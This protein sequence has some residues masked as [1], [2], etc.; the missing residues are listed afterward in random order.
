MFGKAHSGEDGVD[1]HLDLVA[2]PGQE[3]VLYLL[4]TILQT[5]GLR[6]FRHFL[7]KGL[8]FFLHGVDVGKDGAHL[9]QNG[10]PLLEP[11]VLPLVADGKAAA[12][13]DS[14]LVGLQVPGDDIEKGGLPRPVDAH[15]ADAVPVLHP[16]VP[17]PEDQV[18]AKALADIFQRDLHGAVP[19]IS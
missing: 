7:P 15:Q 17:P 10:V 19:L 14:P 12:P 3:S 9:L 5:G 6:I 2:V 1:L 8:E 18:A 16:G 11:G 13:G 4:I